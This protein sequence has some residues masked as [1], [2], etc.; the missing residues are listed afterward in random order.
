M[1]VM[2]CRKYRG[3]ISY[4]EALAE[5]VRDRLVCCF[6]IRYLVHVFIVA[7]LWI[8]H[9]AMICY[10]YISVSDLVGESFK[11]ING[12][13]QTTGQ[14][15]RAVLL[16]PHIIVFSVGRLKNLGFLSLLALCYFAICKYFK[17]KY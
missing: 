11:K 12:G 5:A 9:F 6:W 17:I 2:C 3:Y 1:H 13:S 15:V 10:D 14:Y 16:I 4:P 8:Y 7:S